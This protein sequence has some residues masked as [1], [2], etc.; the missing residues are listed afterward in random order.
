MHTGIPLTKARTLAFLSDKLT[1]SRILP[2]LIIKYG[3][4]LQNPLQAARAVQNAFS[5]TA[6]YVIVRSS[7][8]QE[9]SAQ[10]SNAGR[11]ESVANVDIQNLCELADAV[12]QVFASYQSTNPDEEILIQ[13][14]LKDV[15]CSG[16]AFT[17]DIYTGAPYFTINYAWGEDT[18]AVTSGKT[19]QLKTVVLFKGTPEQ[20]TNSTLKPLIAALFELEEALSSQALD[21]EFAFTKN[22]ELYILQARPI[23]A[24]GKSTISPDSLEQPLR[25]LYKKVEKLTRPH[26][27]LL[28]DST[29]F[30]VMPDWNPAEILGVRPKKLAVSLYKEL[31]TDSI[32]AHQR[33]NYGYLDLTMHPLMA[34]FC[35]IP[36][37]DTRVTFNSFIP[38]SLN[39]Y[40]AEKLANYY[41]DTLRQYPAY[42]D[43]I[44]FEIVYSCYYI[45]LSG[46]LKKLLAHGFNENELK[47]IEF[48]LLNLTNEIIHPETGLYRRDIEIAAALPAQYQAVMDSG[49]SVIDKIYWLLE[50]CKKYGTLPFAGVARAG[51]I[52]VQFLRSFVSSGLITQDEY[53]AFMRSLNTVSK[54]LARDRAKLRGGHMS[55][56]EFMQKYGHIRPGTYDILSPRY[57]EAPDYYF[58]P[59]LEMRQ[60][61]EAESPYQFS[62]AQMASINQAL[63]EHGLS[64]NAE[65]LLRFIRDSIEARESVKFSFTKCISE[66]LRLI[67]ALGERNSISVEDMAYLDISVVKQLYVDLYYGNLSSVLQNNIEMNRRQYE[68]ARLLKLPSV[69]VKPED[70]YCFTLLEEEPNFV[71]LNRIRAEVVKEEKLTSADVEGKIV[72]IRSADPGY[73]FL[74]AKQIGGLVTQFGGANSHMTIRCAELGIPAVIG[75]G[76][77]NYSTWEN[78]RI[79]NI[80]CGGRQVIVEE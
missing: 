58:P 18:A 13:P 28:G 77:K 16:V 20:I 72:F 64:V 79:L 32:W 4:Y 76:E 54:Q 61:M 31:V 50:C 75:A 29:C 17:C 70:V 14:M 21:I 56:A 19:N 71:T 8:L 65:E 41:I 67:K 59:Q 62:A 5:Q 51:F 43:K 44:E 68:C 24:G 69:I 39:P 80:D 27:F 35:G 34:S 47:R 3:D 42:H 38:K 12:R 9:D 11:F 55:Q 48:S 33:N 2:L 49:I 7:S 73:D 63:E 52:A 22:Q 45:G 1:K 30:G 15:A 6:R 10:T 66:I 74:F 57:D 37:I 60:E 36:Y 78:A 40:I 23:A 25:S 26:P 53:D 46:N